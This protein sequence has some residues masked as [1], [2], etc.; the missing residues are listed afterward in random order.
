[1]VVAAE[2]EPF[3]EVARR[4]SPFSLEKGDVSFRKAMFRH[5]SL[6]VAGHFEPAFYVSVMK[7]ADAFFHHEVS[8]E[9]RRHSANVSARGSETETLHE[10]LACLG[11]NARRPKIP[12]G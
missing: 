6:L 4:R 11:R 8:V 9:Y 7:V 1:M 2:I 12:F 5:Q 3:R 10:L